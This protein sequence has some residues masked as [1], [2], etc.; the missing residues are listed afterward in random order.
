MAAIGPFPKDMWSRKKAEFQTALREVKEETGL[1][2]ELV[3]GFRETVEY[4]PKPNISKQ[5]VYFLGKASTDRVVRQEEEISE[6]R[7]LP[8]EEAPNWI[9]FDNHRQLILKAKPLIL[10]ERRKG[11]PFLR[12]EG[13]RVKKEHNP[14]KEEKSCGAVLLRRES[15]GL[16]VLLVR[17]RNGSH[18]SFPKGHVEQGEQERQTALREIREETGLEARLLPEFRTQV[19]YSPKPGVWKQVV[20]FA[21]LPLEGF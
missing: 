13:C 3:D 12:R 1:S 2:I 10:R 15:K 20:Y 14:M 19:A 7:W 11:E 5:V 4:R 8:L 16:E 18:W 21:G 9:S 17:H 6:I